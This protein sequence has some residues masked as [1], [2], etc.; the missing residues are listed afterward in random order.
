MSSKFMFR[1]LLL[2]A[3]F[4]LVASPGLAATLAA[5]ANHTCVVTGSGG[6]RC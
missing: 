2:A 5:G 6:V 4:T 3:S 1:F